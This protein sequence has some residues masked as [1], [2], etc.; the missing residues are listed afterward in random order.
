MNQD[1]SLSELLLR[2]EGLLR[3]RHILHHRGRGP[4]AA[5]HQGQGRVL[6]LLKLKP[7]LG[8]KELSAILDIRPQSLGELLTKLE[9][10]GFITREPSEEDRRSVVVRL[11]EAGRQA[12]GQAVRG[13]DY[14]GFLSC[15]STDEQTAFGAYLERLIAALEA[16][17]ES[18]GPWSPDDF[19]PHSDH[20][21]RGY[22]P[23]H[24]HGPHGHRGR[25]RG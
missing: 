16:E 8:Q 2:L 21:G 6:A 13:P 14:D 18:Q 20:H 9:R 25:D 3:R 11:T 7:E 4:G 15:L 23:G 10:Q 5:P 24:G 19:G 17:L 22:G 1:N 12:S